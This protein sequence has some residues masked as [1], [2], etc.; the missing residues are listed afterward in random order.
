MLKYSY[1]PNER[2]QKMIAIEHT[3]KFVTEIDETNPTGARLLALDKY[4]QIAMLEGALK[5]MVLPAI[6]PVLETIN[7]GGSW[8]IV[9]VAE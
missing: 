4:S 5:E 1:Q 7:A 2:Q 9:K 3:L 8:A 6:V